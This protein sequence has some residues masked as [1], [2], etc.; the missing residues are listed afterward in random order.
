[1]LRRA[2]G[3]FALIVDT[4]PPAARDSSEVTRV[5]KIVILTP[6][7]AGMVVSLLWRGPGKIH[8]FDLDVK[9]Y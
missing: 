4:A 2:L 5:I 6:E 8:G 9:S 1:M 3:Y 7:T